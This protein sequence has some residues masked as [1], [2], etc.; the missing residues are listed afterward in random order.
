[1]RID[2][3]AVRF[4]YRSKCP[5]HFRIEPIP[6]GQQHEIPPIGGIDM[7]PR[8]I[9]RRQRHDLIHLI[10]RARPGRSRR[11]N[12]RANPAGLQLALQ[13]VEID[14]SKRIS[15]DP[16]SLDPEQLA[17]T[18]VGVMRQ[19]RIRDRLVRM[20]LSGN[21][22]RFQIGDRPT[23]RQMPQRSLRVVPE[24]RLHRVDDLDLQFRRGGTTITRMRIRVDTLRDRIRR[25][26]HRMR[27]HQHLRR[28]IGMKER[29]V[30]G[31]PLGQRLDR[32]GH[33]VR[34][35]IPAPI[36]RKC[37]PGRLPSSHPAEP[38]ADELSNCMGNC[39]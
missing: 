28:I 2:H 17:H 9:T 22:E 11:R 38:V 16:D 30:V 36:D 29:V 7:H 3:D 6:L 12:H 25:C 18:R 10:D 13:R 19:M 8:P 14:P 23:R 35:D 33:H 31:Q 15:L 26:R 39:W 21:P 37:P 20:Q 5:R 1:V 34:I 4:P 32:R 24:H 27:R